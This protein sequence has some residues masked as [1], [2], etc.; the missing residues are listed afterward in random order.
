[1]KRI[2][3]FIKRPRKKF[4]IKTTRTKLKNIILS[5]W[6]EW[7]NWKPI[8]NLQKGYGEKLKIQ[9][10]RTKLDNIIFGKFEFKD[11]IKKIK[12]L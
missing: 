2:I 4:E 7:W 8:K 6:I 9:R 5:I 1:L 3:I 10:V 12:L 11:E